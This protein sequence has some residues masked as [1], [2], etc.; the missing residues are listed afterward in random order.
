MEAQDVCVSVSVC[1]CTCTPRNCSNVTLW[2]SQAG[3]VSPMALCS[4]Y[5]PIQVVPLHWG[6]GAGQASLEK[7]P[8][9]PTEMFSALPVDPPHQTPGPGPHPAAGKWQSGRG[10]QVSAPPITP[11]SFHESVSS[12]DREGDTDTCFLSSCHRAETKAGPS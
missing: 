6:A 10:P 9:K 4:L 5:P 8:P 1:I 11:M 2:R 12:G 7:G 3:L